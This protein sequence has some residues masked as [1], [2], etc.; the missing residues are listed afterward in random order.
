MYTPHRINLLFVVLFSNKKKSFLSYF[1]YGTLDIFRRRPFAT[2][3]DV[4]TG[5]NKKV[6]RSTNKNK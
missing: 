1:I 5:R 4:V 2:L 3:V 6:S